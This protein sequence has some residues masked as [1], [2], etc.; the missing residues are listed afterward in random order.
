MPIDANYTALERAVFE[1]ACA[2]CESIWITVN[3]EWAP[4]IKKRIGDYV[5]DPVWYYREY[6]INPSDGR[7]IIPIFFVPHQPKFRNRRDSLGWGVINAAIYVNKVAGG[8]S[9]FV[10]PSRFY[11]AFPFGV[12]NPRELI[13]S[14]LSISSKKPFY[15]SYENKTVKDNMRLGFTFD[16]EDVRSINR[17][18]FKESTGIMEAFGTFVKGDKAAWSRRRP[19]EEQYSA[20]FFSLDKVFQPLS[21]ENANFKELEWYYDISSWE[22][23]RKFMG[24]THILERPKPMTAGA[25]PVIGVDDD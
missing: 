4:L 23:Y 2:G 8:L 14:R 12:Y 18:V 16:W 10:T 25:L 3:D 13:K 9:K 19:V 15:L 17:Y 21:K 6:D 5:Y 11:A 7:K 24:S 22:D 20:R 1:C